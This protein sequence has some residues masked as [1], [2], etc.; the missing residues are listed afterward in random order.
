M[1]N[2]KIPVCICEQRYT[3]CH[4]APHPPHSF[5]VD[6][7]GRLAVVPVRIAFAIQPTVDE[8]SFWVDVTVDSFFM[9]D[10]I[11]QGSTYYLSGRSGQ[12][13]SNGKKIRATA[14]LEFPS[15]TVLLDGCR[16]EDT[17]NPRSLCLP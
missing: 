13:V 2:K 8:A 11:I 10:L 15:T 9:F 6:L 5:R 14:L 3:Q 17:H 1:T 12:W 4:G 7:R 16:T